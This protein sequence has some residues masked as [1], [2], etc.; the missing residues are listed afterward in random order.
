V[1]ENKKD[2]LEKI[3]EYCV[4]SLGDSGYLGMD[5]YI[6]QGSNKIEIQ[7]MNLLPSPI[8]N[9]YETHSRI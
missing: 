4:Y 9:F 6:M 3:E 7:L 1:K 8:K 5:K 2:F